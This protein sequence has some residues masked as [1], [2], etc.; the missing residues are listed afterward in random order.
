MTLAAKKLNFSPKLAIALVAP[1]LLCLGMPPLGLAEELEENSGPGSD[2][3]PKMPPKERYLAVWENS[4]FELEAPPP[5]PPEQPEVKSFAEEMAL[6]GIFEM[7]DT[8]LI[9]VLDRATGEYFEVGKQAGENGIRLVEV[10]NNPDPTSASAKI[11]KGEEEATIR[12]DQ[13]LLAAAPQP[14]RHLPS[15]PAAVNRNSRLRSPIRPATPPPR[16]VP[17]R[18][19]SPPAISNNPAP[20]PRAVQPA[21]N[22]HSPPQL[23][24]SAGA[25]PATQPQE[26]RSPPTATQRR[27]VVVPV[28][29]PRS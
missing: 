5:P 15:A 19:G 16:S 1:S 13:K 24:G 29:R 2:V 23:P 11:A 22:G 6:A 7:G 21:N 12:Y 20:A 25:P 27:R 8:A 26:L 9:T 10:A 4:P 3:I 17:P 28:A 14:A 18:L